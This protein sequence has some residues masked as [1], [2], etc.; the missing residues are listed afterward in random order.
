MPLKARLKA[1]MEIGPQT[2]NMQ[3][4]VGD[5]SRMVLLSSFIGERLCL[6]AVGA[7]RTT[8]RTEL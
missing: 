3:Y 8:M 1:R 4:T 7:I 6:S 2:I 5:V